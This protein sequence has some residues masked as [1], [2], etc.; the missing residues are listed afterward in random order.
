MPC[1]V[2]I[3]QADQ[4]N[5][6][7]KLLCKACK[8][9]SADQIKTLTNPRSGLYD[10]LNWYVQHLLLDYGRN[11]NEEE[12]SIALNELNRLGFTISPVSGGLQLMK[13]NS[14]G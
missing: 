10:G 8:Y 3:T 9:L 11:S 13:K 1:T 6:F 12:K 7:I 14:N 5:H 2:D 4:T